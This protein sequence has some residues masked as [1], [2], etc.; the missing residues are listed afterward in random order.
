[1]LPPIHLD[2]SKN[3]RKRARDI[4]HQHI[5]HIAFEKVWTILRILLSPLLAYPL[6]TALF[7]LNNSYHLSL[8]LYLLL[9][10]PFL[11]F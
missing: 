5:T 7:W 4:L 9:F 2:L 6:N 10:L 8:C 11:H 3:G 1:M